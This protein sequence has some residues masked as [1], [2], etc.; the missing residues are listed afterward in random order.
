MIKSREKYLYGEDPSEYDEG[1][2]GLR[3]NTRI[4][5]SCSMCCNPRKSKLLKRKE[6]LTVQ[7]LKELEKEKMKLVNDK[8]E[9]DE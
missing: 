9:L 3:A 1:Y 6:K 8:E 2:F 7:E 4:P 5:C